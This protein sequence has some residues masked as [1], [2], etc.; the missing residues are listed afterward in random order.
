MI[1]EKG[2]VTLSPLI[3]EMVSSFRKYYR[4]YGD[5][6]LQANYDD[7]NLSVLDYAISKLGVKSVELK[8]GQAAK[9][10]QG[11]GRVKDI[12]DALKFQKMVI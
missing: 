2:K 7:E 9:G 11:M 3:A 4:G 10:I 1:L 8:F 6:I 5:I 12:E